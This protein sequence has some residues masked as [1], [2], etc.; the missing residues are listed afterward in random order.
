MKKF[1]YKTTKE[2]CSRM[3]AGNP[4]DPLML[5]VVPQKAELKYVK[6]F[7]ND[8]LQEHQASPIPGLLHKYYGRV[9]LLTT[10]NCAANCRF[11]FR[12]NTR[13]KVYNWSQV[14]R[15]I[16]ND[17]T[18]TEVILSGGDPLMLAEAKLSQI[19]QK[20][21]AI[22]HVKRLRIHTRVPVMLPKI[23]TAK[24]IKV[25][26]ASRLPVV[27]VVHINHA[28]E[29]D[30]SVELALRKFLKVGIMIFNQSVLLRGINDSPD[31]LCA[32]SEKL[33]ALGVI[34]YYLHLLDQVQGAAHFYVGPK[35]A[36]K[37]VAAMQAKLPGYLVPKL[38]YEQPGAKAKIQI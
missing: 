36:K 5:Q 14:F 10:N 3:R 26:R 38:V 27:L 7:V 1:P 35:R 8:P 19:L 21:A 15:Y 6:G 11:C 22:K 24:L 34:P 23:I 37:I 4:N 25:L 17:A 16:K 18:I 30:R 2:F 31:T 13:E 20:I 29:I 28:Q 12:R 9:L 33:F 32:L